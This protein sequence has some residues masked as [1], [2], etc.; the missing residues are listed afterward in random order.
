M[1]AHKIFIFFF[2]LL[3]NRLSL[4]N[5]KNQTKIDVFEEPKIGS[6]TFCRAFPFHVLFD[7]DMS[8]KQVGDSLRRILPAS[9]EPNCRVTD[10]L[11]MVNI[12]HLF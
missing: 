2:A 6:D 1:L 11:H 9:V 7:R 3:C 10:I 12:A 4:S 5:D 8:I